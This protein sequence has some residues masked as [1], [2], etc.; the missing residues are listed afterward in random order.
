MDNGIKWLQSYTAN[1]ANNLYDN[2]QQA[3]AAYVLARNGVVVTAFI[4]N[5]EERLK[6]E[7]DW[8]S[9]DIVVY[10]AGIYKLLQMDEKALDMIRSFVPDTV[11]RYRFFSDFDS[12]TLRNTVYLYFLA[13]HFP[14]MISKID[15]KI[16]LN[17]INAIEDRHYSTILSSYSIL[18]LYALAEATEGSDT[19]LTVSITS[20]GKETL[21]K[22]DTDGEFPV[23]AYEGRAERLTA[24]T[25]ERG[26]MGFFLVATEQ[27][28]DKTLPQAEARGIEV[29]RTYFDADGKPKTVF[30][31]GDDVTVRLRVRTN[32]NRNT[33]DNVAII[34]LLPGAFE[35]QSPAV[36]ELQKSAYSGSYGNR[37]FDYVD[38]REDRVIFYATVTGTAKEMTYKLK[39]VSKGE[40]TLPPVYASS[41]YDPVYRGNTKADRITVSE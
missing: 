34:D 24:K 29:T 8:R 6:K 4:T 17:L 1:V 5:L 20:N 23:A 41:M 13:K 9:N 7:K 14:D 31:Q 35:M 27:G 2:R 3:Y 37:L 18:A 40:Y 11:E 25:A 16:V 39:V 26:K 33:I 12:S 15:V 30:K 22:V 32:G 38:V 19:G 36:A 28:F 10:M 21:L